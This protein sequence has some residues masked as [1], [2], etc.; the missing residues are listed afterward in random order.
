MT[1]NLNDL[2]DIS[3]LN[4]DG[5]TLA[6]EGDDY[7]PLFQA[8][9][10]TLPSLFIRAGELEEVDTFMLE[11]IND[12]ID[13]KNEHI[14]FGGTATQNAV[15]TPHPLPYLRRRHQRC[16]IHRAGKLILEPTEVLR[17]SL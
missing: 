12:D 17:H 14:V 8:Q 13:E 6:D 10:D 16:P 3:F 11:I 5:S 1:L 4:I 9:L 7:S 2:D 15:V